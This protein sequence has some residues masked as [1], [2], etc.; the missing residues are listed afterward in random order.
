MDAILIKSTNWVGDAVLQTPT[1]RALR[2]GFPEARIALVARPWVAPLFRGHPDIDEVFIEPEEKSERRDLVR[3]LR[4]TRWDLGLALPNSFSAARL[5][6]RARAR[7]RR[8]HALDGRRWLLTDSIRPAPHLRHGHEVDYYL[9]LLDGLMGSSA[10]DRQPCVPPPREAV[11]EADEVLGAALDEAGL[12]CD[13]PL[14][15]LGAT[16]AH[17]T[18]KRWPPERH[19]EVAR[20]LRERH[21]LIPL[22]A[23]SETERADTAGIARLIGP[24][25]LDLAGRFDVAVLAAVLARLRLFVTNDSGPM[26][27]AAAQGTPTLA[28]FGSTNWRTTAP[29]GPR[30]R[31]VREPTVCA[32]CLRRHCPTDHR[33]MAAI[34]VDRVLA[35]AEE[36]IR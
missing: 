30:T 7:R 3:Q 14:L 36:M 17:G 9:H 33:C 26:H 21:G 15:G 12:P 34:G 13:T 5:L 29:L 2:R 1:L 25:V 28:I 22:L 6:W 11:A 23:G 31:I 18:A 20:A 8:G 19:A 24:P 10:V 16:A 4:G 35:A 32:P 27:L